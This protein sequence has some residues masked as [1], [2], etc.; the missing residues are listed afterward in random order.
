MDDGS[1]TPALNIIHD[2][3]SL[4]SSPHH[5]RTKVINPSIG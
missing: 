1:T 4:P 3:P 2:P 5:K